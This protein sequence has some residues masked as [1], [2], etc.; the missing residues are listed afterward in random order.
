[1]SALAQIREVGHR[2]LVTPERV[3]SKYN[4]DLIFFK[5]FHKFIVCIAVGERM[6]LGM[7]GFDFAQI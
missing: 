1:V 3:L 2:L 4:V 5:G 6:F 7:Q